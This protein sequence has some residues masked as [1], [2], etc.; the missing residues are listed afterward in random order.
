[1]KK[2]PPLKW[3]ATPDKVGVATLPSRARGTNAAQ[4]VG[5]IYG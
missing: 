2:F 4:R 3:W 5:G 1:M